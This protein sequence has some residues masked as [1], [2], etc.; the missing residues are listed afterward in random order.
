MS[1][2]LIKYSL[3]TFLY[4]LFY[5]SLKHLKSGCLCWWSMEELMSCKS[6]WGCVCVCVCHMLCFLFLG[7]R[8]KRLY[9]VITHQKIETPAQTNSSLRQTSNLVV[10]HFFFFLH[11]IN[12][13]IGSPETSLI[14]SSQKCEKVPQKAN[15]RS[16]SLLCSTGKHP[17]SRDY[18]AGLLFIF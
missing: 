6:S 3:K 16:S 12:W 13:M 10:S 15:T 1:P 5:V 8:L 4:G 9:A 2:A 14:V 7:F 11:L 18:S 17:E